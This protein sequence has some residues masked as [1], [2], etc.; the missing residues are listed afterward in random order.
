MRIQTIA[1]A[2]QVLTIADMLAEETFEPVFEQLENS[3]P[4]KCRK[5]EYSDDY[6]KA[7]KW[8][9]FLH[10]TFENGGEYDEDGYSHNCTTERVPFTVALDSTIYNA[11]RQIVGEIVSL[12][13]D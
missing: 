7:G 11:V 5:V 4:G 3:L 12:I 13:E 2:L 8:V 1:P 9:L 6:E 10:V